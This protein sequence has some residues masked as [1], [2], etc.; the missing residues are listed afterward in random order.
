MIQKTSIRNFPLTLLAISSALILGSSCTGPDPVAE[1]TT[2]LSLANVEEEKSESSTTVL[3]SKDVEWEALNPARGDK[4]PMAGTLWGD[5]KGEVPTGFLARFVDGFSS[6]PHIHNVTYRAVVISGKVHN[7][8]ANAEEMWMGPGS[9]WTQPLGQPH[10][11]SAQGETNIAL[12]EINRGPYLVNP[13]EEAF[14]NGERPIN[15]DASNVIW[16]K[17][18]R[19]QWIEEGSEAEISFLSEQ[20]TPD[21]QRSLFVKLPQGYSGS[22]STTGTTHAVV[23][24]GKVNLKHKGQDLELDPGSYFGA[25]QEETHVLKNPS[26]QEA[27]I[28]L[29]TSG[30]IRVK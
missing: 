15:M 12:V 23:I 8:D 26:D 7:D 19:A 14:D 24:S 27:L 25:T 29:R 3:L 5:R 4:S 6:P 18:D 11:T 16:L 10:I 20:S 22:L 30:E 17:A 13:I 21:V 9:F 1:K 28:Y 2:D